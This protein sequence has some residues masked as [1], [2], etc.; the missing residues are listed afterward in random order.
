M[1]MG[2]REFSAGSE[3]DGKTHEDYESPDQES[4]IDHLSEEIPG[5]GDIHG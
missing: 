1:K 3:T 4:L 2:N 5:F